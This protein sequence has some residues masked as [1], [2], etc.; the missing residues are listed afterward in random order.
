MGGGGDDLPPMMKNPR[1]LSGQARPEQTDPPRQ[2]IVRLV[3]G[4]LQRR[5]ERP[6]TSSATSLA[7]PWFTWSG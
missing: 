2:L 5:E 6:A 3:Q 4:P 7:T 1:Q